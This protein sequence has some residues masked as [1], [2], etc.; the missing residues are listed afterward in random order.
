MFLRKVESKRKSGYTHT[1]VQLVESYRN[2]EGKTRTRILYHF[3]PLDKFLQADA[4]KLVDSVLKMKGEVFLDHL[5]KFGSAKDFGDLF[6]IF[7]LLK[8]LK[9]FQEI[10]KIKESETRIGFDLVGHINALICNRV[11]DPSSKLKLLSWL[12]SVYIP[13]LKSSE[14]SYNNL[15][16]SMDFLIKHKKRIEEH[17]AERVLSIFDLSLHM[18]F[19][20]ITSSYFETNNLSESDIRCYGYS[21]DSRPDRVQVTIG[22]VMTEEGIPIAHY[23]FPG[24]TADV[25]TLQE[26][27]EDIKDRFG[28][29]REVSI[30]TDKGMTSSKNIDYLLSGDHL[31]IVGESKTKKISREI[32]SEA[33]TEQEDKESGFTYEKVIPYEYEVDGIKKSCNLRYVCSFNPETYRLNAE[34]FKVK[35]ADYEGKLSEINAKDIDSADKYSQL[36]SWLKSHGMIKWFDLSIQGDIVISKSNDS[37]LSSVQAGFGWFLIKSNL[38]WE[39]N[40]EEIVLGYKTLWKVEHGFREL[41]HSLDIR[42]MYHWTDRRIMAHVFLCFISMVATS[43]VEKR[44]KDSGIDMSWEKCLYEMR[45][46]K[47]IDYRTKS[48]IYGHAISGISKQQEKLFKAVGCPKPKLGHL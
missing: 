39:W 1:T 44:L 21:R 2:E 10:E 11:N 41:K 42:P 27:V 29:F 25:S 36:K 38:S 13:E 47:V 17:L 15:L 18:C 16:R 5:E 26:V 22:V 23:V 45:K 40:K 6:T 3:G 48:G 33:N 4:D 9:F 8:E 46:I 7:R 19:Y 35:L 32:L 43:V 28:D 14:V 24:N 30:V 20:D 12:E 31:F 34:R 37:V